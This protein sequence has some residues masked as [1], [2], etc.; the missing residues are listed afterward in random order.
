MLDKSTIQQLRQLPIEAV[1][2]RLGLRVSRHKSLCPFH[3]DHH[4]SL[5]FNTRT[6]TYRCF[7][8]DTHG[9]TIDLVM[10]HLHKPFPDACRWLADSTNIIVEEYK[11]LPQK[12]KTQNSKSLRRRA[13]RPILRAP[14]AQRR[15]A[16]VSLRRAKTRPTR[17]SMVP[18]HLVDRPTR[19]P[20]ATNALLR[21]KPKPHRPPKP[22]PRFPSSPK[23]TNLIISPRTH[24]TPR[25]PSFL[26][27]P[28]PLRRPMLHLQS[29]RHPH[30]PSHRAPIHHRRLL[31]L[32]V[33]ALLRSQSRS[34]TISN[35][36]HPSRQAAPTRPLR[37]ARHDLPHVSRP[38]HTRRT[39]LHATKRSFTFVGASSAATRLQRLLRLLCFIN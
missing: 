21:P 3:D 33:H 23:I 27:L 15:S 2:E 30:A 24:R 7:A 38:R 25:T 22:K 12:L 8:C 36:P 4:A 29:P 6:N 17:R 16:K 32:L 20:L 13:L 26:S 19:H 14:L 10:N 1:A 28:L 18:P 37:P 9:G 5:T 35:A 34:H 31:R 39:T 11:P